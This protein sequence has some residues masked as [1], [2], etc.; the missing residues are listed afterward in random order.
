ML[1][2]IRKGGTCLTEGLDKGSESQ[3]ELF[4]CSVAA[5]F[6]EAKLL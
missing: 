2:W 1:P 6:T 3:A 5:A 4:L